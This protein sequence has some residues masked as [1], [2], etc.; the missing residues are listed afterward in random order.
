MSKWCAIHPNAQI[1]SGDGFHWIRLPYIAWVPQGEKN[2]F[3]ESLGIKT[4]KVLGPESA[5]RMYLCRAM[6]STFCIGK[7]S[8]GIGGLMFV[9][10]VRSEK[11]VFQ[12][13]LRFAE[14][15]ETKMWSYGTNFYVRVLEGDHWS[16]DGALE[17]DRVIGEAIQ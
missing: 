12:L 17:N 16:E 5:M 7:E 3:I 15:V 9:I 14:A 13:K 10:G 2:P 6:N 4:D 8:S 1:S 11:D